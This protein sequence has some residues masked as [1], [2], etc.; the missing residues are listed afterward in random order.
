MFYTLYFKG[1]FEHCL[2]LYLKDSDADI[3]VDILVLPILARVVR[4]TLLLS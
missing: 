2:L 4:C 3:L 1:A